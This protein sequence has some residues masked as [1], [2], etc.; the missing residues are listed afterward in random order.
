MIVA[1]QRIF[2][3]QAARARVLRV[4]CGVAG[5]RSPSGSAAKVAALARATDSPHEPIEEWHIDSR[6][7]IPSEQSLFGLSRSRLAGIGMKQ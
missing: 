1:G 6:F 7:H 5:P 3:V 4:R 2:E